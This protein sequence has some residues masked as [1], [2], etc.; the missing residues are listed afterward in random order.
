M[1]SMSLMTRIPVE[2][3]G[4]VHELDIS[5]VSPHQFAV[6]GPSKQSMANVSNK[7]FF[8]SE[9]ISLHLKILTSKCNLLS[10]GAPRLASRFKL[11]YLQTSRMNCGLFRKCFV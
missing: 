8:V 10:N 1:L 2:N 3:I 9:N 11:Q 6:Y 7:G 5:A 4:P